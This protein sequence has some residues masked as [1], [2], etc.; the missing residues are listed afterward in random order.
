MADNPT[1]SIILPDGS[2]EEKTI[3]GISGTTITVSSAFS[4]APNQ[5]APYI[6]ETSN[7][8]TT[9]WRV[10]SVKEN[11]NK[12]FAVL[13]PYLITLLNMLL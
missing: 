5:H 9:T 1:I 12:T 7:L 8:Q 2:L 10:V 13:Q 3:S 11:E 6:L 4:T